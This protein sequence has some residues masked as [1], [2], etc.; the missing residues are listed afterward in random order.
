MSTPTPTTNNMGTHPTDRHIL[1]ATQAQTILSASAAE[2]ASINTPVNIAITDPSG[3]LLA[4]LRTDNAFPGS[5]DIAQ[6]KARTVSLFNGAWCTADLYALTQPGG[7]LYG[8]QDSN[9]GLV[10]FG[11]GVP[12]ML[13]GRFVGAVGV[14]G[15]TTG[16]DVRIATEGVRSVGGVV[17]WEVEK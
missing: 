9:G 17:G 16:E 6:R 13:D 15:G 8:I 4:F 1:T 7:A 11:G 5:I 3:Q 12:V 10:V 2:S 14:S